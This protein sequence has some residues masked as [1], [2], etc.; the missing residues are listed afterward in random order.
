MAGIAGEPPELVVSEPPLAAAAPPVESDPPD[1]HPA[2]T[3]T[4]PSRAATVAGF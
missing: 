4:A 3:A 2:S 1:P